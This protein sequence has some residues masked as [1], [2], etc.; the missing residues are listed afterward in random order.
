MAYEA[1]HAQTVVPSSEHDVP[2]KFEKLEFD[3]DEQKLMFVYLMSA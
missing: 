2:V 1:E 3:M